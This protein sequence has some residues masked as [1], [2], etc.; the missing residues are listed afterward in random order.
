VKEALM[1]FTSASDMELAVLQR[2]LLEARFC[3]ES[4]D[5]DVWASPLVID[6]HV[7]VI[8]TLESRAKTSGN[9]RE[10]KRIESWLNWSGHEIEERILVERLRRDSM[11]LSLPPERREAH[12]EELIR[13]FRA[14][15]D[16]LR[17][18]RDRI[19]TS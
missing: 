7:S 12:L 8:E 1:D 4:R 17:L 9:A 2:A 6:L 10:V 5:E 3:T 13:P 11:W 18:L 14:G 19:E 16:A 15:D